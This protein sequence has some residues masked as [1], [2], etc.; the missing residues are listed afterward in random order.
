M[1]EAHTLLNRKAGRE[2]ASAC[3]RTQTEE[4][5]KCLETPKAYAHSH[6]IVA[7]GLLLTS[8]TTR[9][10]PRTSLMMRVLTRLSTA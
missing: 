4:E 7:G 9:L 10:M 8:Y 2:E 3:T 5:I 6:S 1:D